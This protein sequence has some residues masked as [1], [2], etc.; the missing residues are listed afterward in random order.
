MSERITMTVRAEV[1][2]DSHAWEETYGTGQRT[3]VADVEDYLLNLIE[4]SAAATE[5]AIS[6]TGWAVHEVER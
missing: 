3:V 5:G 4:D 2:V 1:E 6:C